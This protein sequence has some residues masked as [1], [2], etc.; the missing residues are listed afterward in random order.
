MYLQ[1]KGNA[2][3]KSFNVKVTRQEP[4]SREEVAASSK[5]NREKLE[6]KF[7]TMLNMMY[8][9]FKEAFMFGQTDLVM[10]LRDQ[11]VNPAIA[12]MM[13]LFVR[14]RCRTCYLGRHQDITWR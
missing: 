7:C 5:A 3:I 2:R 13:N 1:Q 11:L 4:K 14:S 6:A 9:A 10:E 12:H 8:E